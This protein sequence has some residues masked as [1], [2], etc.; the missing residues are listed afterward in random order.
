MKETLSGIQS[1]KEQVERT[2]SASDRLRKTVDGYVTSVKS[3]YENLQLWEQ[4]LQSYQTNLTADARKMLDEVDKHCKNATET[5]SNATSGIT[6]EFKEKT[7]A[8]L[9]G[10]TTQNNKLD[11]HVQEMGSLRANIEKAITEI[12]TLKSSLTEIQS[13]L[14]ISQDDQDR[15]IAALDNKLSTLP[16]T[17]TTSEESLK[18][19]VDSKCQQ[20][21]TQVAKNININRWIMIAGIILLAALHFLK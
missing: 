6:E 21:F 1:A 11:T 14:K 10:F 15:A 7:S 12:N 5:I 3:L 16:S 8:A 4:Q 18:S 19:F 17:I 9:T 13:E 2:T 20:L